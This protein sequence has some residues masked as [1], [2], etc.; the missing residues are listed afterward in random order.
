MTAVG[1]SLKELSIKG[2]GFP[3][4]ADADATINLGGYTNEQQ[5]NG[6]GS[7]RIVKTVVPWSITGVSVEID[8]AR[9]DL[10]FLQ[11]VAAM[12]DNVAIAITLV[13]DVVYQR[14]G[15]IT[16]NVELS[17]QNTTAPLSLSGP[18]LLGKQ[19]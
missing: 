14:E 9:G 3:V 10:E 12:T 18:F 6:N 17:T 15:T 11:E 19:A 5:P 13:N 2:R 8:H 16:D 7:A 4:A 1:G